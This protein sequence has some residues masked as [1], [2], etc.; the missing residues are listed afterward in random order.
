M[1]VG[2]DVRVVLR[3]FFFGLDGENIV[4]GVFCSITS[5]RGDA[6]TDRRGSCDLSGLPISGS[7][8]LLECDHSWSGR[9]G[10]RLGVVI[11]V[12]IFMM[13]LMVVVEESTNAS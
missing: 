2:I 3:R 10:I 6:S 13:V 5:R 1:R 4:L 11:T 9:W 8:W 7:M 12:D